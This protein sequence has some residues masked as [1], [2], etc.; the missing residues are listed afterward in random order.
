MSLLPSAAACASSPSTINSPSG[1]AEPICQI[2]LASLIA[3]TS[4]G[5]KKNDKHSSP[6]TC[7][8]VQVY[9]S[10]GWPISTDPAT[11]SLNLPRQCRPKLPLRT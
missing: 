6:Q 11:S 1:G 5:L 4:S 2:S 7:S 9:S 3:S 8:W 10:P